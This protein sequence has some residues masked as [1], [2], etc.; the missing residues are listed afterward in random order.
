MNLKELEDKHD[1]IFCRECGEGCMQITW[2]HLK[3]HNMD[4]KEYKEKYPGAPTMCQYSKDEKAKNLTKALT[5]RA[6]HNKGKPMTEE[7][8]RKLTE[9]KKGKATRTGAV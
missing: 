4:T 1:L 8:K 3:R 7:Q 5:G 2:H 6:A 9:A